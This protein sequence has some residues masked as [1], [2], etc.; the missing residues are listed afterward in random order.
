MCAFLIKTNRFLCS[1]S[2]FCFIAHTPFSQKPPAVSQDRP[3]FLFCL[4]LYMACA[5]A[6]AFC[7]FPGFRKLLLFF[8][9][10]LPSR[11]FAEKNRRSR[12]VNRA[13][14]R[15]FLPLAKSLCQNPCLRVLKQPYQTV[16]L[17][18][19]TIAPAGCCL[20]RL[21]MLCKLCFQT[22]EPGDP[23]S[24]PAKVPAFLPKPGFLI[25][26]GSQPH[27]GRCTEL[28]PVFEPVPFLLS[29]RF[30]FFQ[31]S[32]GRLCRF[33]IFLCPLPVS[34][35]VLLCLCLPFPELRQM[36]VLH[37]L[38][39]RLFQQLCLTAC[40]ICLFFQFLFPGKKCPALFPLRLK[41]PGGLR[42]FLMETVDP[43]HLRLHGS[44][45]PGKRLQCC[46]QAFQADS[47]HFFL[48]D[49]PL[50]LCPLLYFQR[51]PGL[52]LCL[53]LL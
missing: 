53:L 22:F 51:K 9:E 5:G 43:L 34:Q 39:S 46:F 12:M 45:F 25:F 14:D 35:K 23:L 42:G 38:P 41:F 48:P 8:L 1:H 52:C 37:L 27:T 18:V 24:Q 2:V 30:L 40:R 15:T 7:R 26:Q 19:Q 16:I 49:L 47:P 11:G 28:Q 36:A 20:I 29:V 6:R 21:L 44:A 32:A 4:F 50:K 31:N 10:C 13:A 33:Q 17:P 3:S